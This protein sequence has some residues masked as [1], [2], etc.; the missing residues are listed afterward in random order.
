MTWI[1]TCSFCAMV[2][3]TNIDWTRSG[4]P[5]S[6]LGPVRVFAFFLLDGAQRGAG[7]GTAHGPF[8][9]FDSAELWLMSLCEGCT[10]LMKISLKAA[11]Y[12]LG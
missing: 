5:T 8:Q 1:S 12:C 4:I 6:D 11:K 9:T 10:R 3:L 7:E 2:R